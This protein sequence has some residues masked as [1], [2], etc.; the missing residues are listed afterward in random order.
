MQLG[1]GVAH[2]VWLLNRCRCLKQQQ[3]FVAV[4]LVAAC[5][6]RLLLLTASHLLLSVP[7]ILLA[8][9]G[10]GLGART[11]HRAQGAQG[12]SRMVTCITIPYH[13]SNHNR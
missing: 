1:T 2:P 8:G 10:K 9:L 5:C 13:S 7:G 4:L 12:A 11:L 6:N 3:Q